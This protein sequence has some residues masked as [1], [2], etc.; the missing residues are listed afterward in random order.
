MGR[1]VPSRPVPSRP[2]A[3][4]AQATPSSDLILHSVLRLP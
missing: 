1:R 2:V 3:A 4:Q